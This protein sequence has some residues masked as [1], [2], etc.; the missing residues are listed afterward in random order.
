VVTFCVSSLLDPLPEASFRREK[1]QQA[2]A[3][4]SLR[5]GRYQIWHRSFAGLTMAS[6]A[7][8]WNAWANA[9]RFESGPFTRKRGMGWGLVLASSRAYSG[10][11]LSAQI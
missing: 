10:R 4:Q 5:S 3:L 6:P 11:M 1:R 9:G 8:Q 2:A 7:L